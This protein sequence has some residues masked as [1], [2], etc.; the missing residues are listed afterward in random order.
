[1]GT[2]IAITLLGIGL[3]LAT[4]ACIV[5]LI[6]SAPTT[7]TALLVRIALVLLLAN[8]GILMATLAAGG[9]LWFFATQCAGYISVFAIAPVIARCIYTAIRT[10]FY[11]H[12]YELRNSESLRFRPRFS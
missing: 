3:L 12:T 8:A 6:L 10:A 11:N 1:M 2:V 4:C 5:P 9:N 7:R